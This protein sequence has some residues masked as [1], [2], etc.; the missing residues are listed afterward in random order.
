MVVSHAESGHSFTC[1]RTC[2]WNFSPCR[3]F[4]ERG[5]N[6]GYQYFLLF[7]KCFLASHKQFSIFDQHLFC[8]LQMLWIW[9]SPKFHRFVKS[10]AN[11]VDNIHQEE[12]AAWNMSDIYH[13][14]TVAV[15]LNDPILFYSCM[16][17]W[18]FVY[19]EFKG[20]K[21][22]LNWKHLQMTK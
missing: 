21:R 8:C 11:I 13:P 6:A 10:W 1:Y 2:R 9:T 22:Y 7:P 14:I 5:E 4:V 20:L 16:T 15:T 18:Y 19:L 12:C 3:D 17:Y